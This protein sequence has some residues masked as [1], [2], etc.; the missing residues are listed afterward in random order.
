[1]PVLRVKD[2]LYF[3]ENGK[4]ISELLDRDKIFAGQAPESFVF[5]KYFIINQT[6]S[7]EEI[8]TIRGSSE[9]AF[10]HGL[11]IKLIDGDENNYKI[12]TIADLEKFK[13]YIAGIKN[14]S[15]RT[16]SNR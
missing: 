9:I 12:T 1:M 7:I 3:S 13:N 11:K 10:K 4:I 8:D 6:A 15:I 14:E 2:T 5:G 16:K